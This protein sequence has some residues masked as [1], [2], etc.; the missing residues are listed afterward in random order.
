MADESRTTIYIIGA[1]FTGTTIAAEIRAK[2]IFGHVVAFL[3]DD[4]AK[5]GTRIDGIPVLGPIEAAARDH[6]DHPRG[7]GDHRHSQRD[8][9][10]ARQ[11]LRHPPPGQV[12]PHPHRAP[13][14]PDPRRRGAPHPG[15]RDR[16]RG[17]PGAQPR[18][19]EPRR[20]ASPTCGAD[21]C[22]SPGAGGSIG[23]ELCRQLLEGGAE[24]LYLF[25]HGEN[26]I[27]EIERELRL[28]QEEG[29]GEKATIVPDHRGDAGQ[30]LPALHPLAHPRER[31]LP[32]RGAQARAPDGGQPRR[33][34]EEQRLRHEEHRRCVEEERRGAVRAHLHRQG[35]GAQL[36]LRR[37][38]APGGGDRPARGQERAPFPGR[39]FRQRPGLPREHP[40]PFPPPDPQGRPGDRHA[41]GDAALL[42]DHPRGLLPRAEG[43][44]RGHA[45][46]R[47]TCW[48][49]GRASPSRSW[50]SR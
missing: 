46:A 4:P 49:W 16:S 32:H 47:S 36:R 5:I 28:L 48:T 2:R 7:R 17:L 8:A 50:P 37:L 23:S 20:R 1:G 9:R 25:G 12:R 38:Q 34:G 27:Y 40:A 42:H 10:A 24:R 22:S 15:A 31:R 45:A 39:A 6:Q 13:D 3:D 43:R 26:S 19:G 14:R 33:G 30:G 41:P 44:R 18:A 21:A 11:D 35:R 29:V